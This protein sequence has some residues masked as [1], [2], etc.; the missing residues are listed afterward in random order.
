MKDNFEF[1][2]PLKLSM[3]IKRLM[4][5]HIIVSVLLILSIS[6]EIKILWDFKN[7]TFSNQTDFITVLASAEEI[8]INLSLLFI[9]LFL[10]GGILIFKWIHRCNKNVRALGSKQMKFSPG[11]SVG[12]FFVP[13]ANLFKPFHVM[14]EIWSASHSPN[15]WSAN[16]KPKA[17][18]KWWILWI[19]SNSVPQISSNLEE[20]AD[21]R[22]L[23][24]SDIVEA[25]FGVLFSLYEDS[26]NGGADFLKLL[27]RTSTDP[28]NVIWS[29]K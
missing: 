8:T 2:S 17:I 20:K 28:N 19:A 10:G 24:P 11:W 7:G 15:D 26:K 4:Y 21:G 27:S 12:W 5:A 6:W 9:S 23:R 29:K 13:I 25:F 3:W 16:E 1:K 18:L 14:N 22:P